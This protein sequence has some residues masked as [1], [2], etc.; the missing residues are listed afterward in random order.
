MRTVSFWH[1]LLALAYGQFGQKNIHCTLVNNQNPFFCL[2]PKAD[3]ESEDGRNFQ[4]NK[5]TNQDL[6]IYGALFYIK[7]QYM[8]STNVQTQKNQSF[9]FVH[10]VSAQTSQEGS[11]CTKAKE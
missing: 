7:I 6:Q 8:S 2:R 10:T 4:A 5:E 9:S 11:K 3:T 1:L